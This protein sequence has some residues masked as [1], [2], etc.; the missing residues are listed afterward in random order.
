[1]KANI[2][3]ETSKRAAA[4]IAEAAGSCDL[5]AHPFGH[6]SPV[7]IVMVVL[8][9][10]HGGDHRHPHDDHYTGKVLTWERETLL[11]STIHTP[12]PRF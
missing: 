3:A 5:Q 6:V 4:R 1:M 8:Q 7:R 11:Y 12:E 9:N 10:D 2:S